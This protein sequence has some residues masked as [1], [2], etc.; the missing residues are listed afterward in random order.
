MNQNQSPASNVVP[1]IRKL[2]CR[3]SLKIS[4]QST[5]LIND[6]AMPASG[7][8][9]SLEKAS[10]WNLCPSVRAA[11]LWMQIALGMF[12][13]VQRLK[14]YKL[15]GVRWLKWT[16]WSADLGCSKFCGRQVPALR[17]DGFESNN[18]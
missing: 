15:A 12:S 3:L 17:F 8:S 13:K 18:E 4:P 11:N 16:S 10:G 1:E 9:P 5:A 14:R 2:I 6:A 7:T